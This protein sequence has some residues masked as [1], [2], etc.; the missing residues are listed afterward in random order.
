MYTLQKKQKKKLTSFYAQ[1]LL[2]GMSANLS[3]VVYQLFNE[4][5]PKKMT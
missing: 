3:I 2:G 1:C 4:A 5:Y